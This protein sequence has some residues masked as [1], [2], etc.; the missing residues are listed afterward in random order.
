MY[1][2][3]DGEACFVGRIGG[4]EYGVAGKGGDEGFEGCANE[5]WLY[6]SG[7]SG[8]IAEKMCYC[9]CVNLS[10]G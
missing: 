3:V 9:L 8:V 2:V 6:D 7:M 4:K 10:I 5:C 1:T